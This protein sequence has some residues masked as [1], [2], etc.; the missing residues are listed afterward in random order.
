ML[1]ISCDSSG[2][3]SGSNNKSYLFFNISNAKAF[4]AGRDAQNTS[5][6]NILLKQD[7]SGDI[8]P[9]VTGTDNMQFIIHKIL[10]NPVTNELL[11][12]GSFSGYRLIRIDQNSNHYGL[13]AD[14]YH[15]Y[16]NADFDN[17][18]A[19]YFTSTGASNLAN[20]WKYENNTATSIAQSPTTSSTGFIVIHKILGNGYVAYSIQRSSG[21]DT[22]LRAQNGGLTSITPYISYDKMGVYSSYNNTWYYGNKGFDF[23][24]MTE[25][26]SGATSVAGGNDFEST[27]ATFTIIEKT[28]ITK[29]SIQS[30]KTL[31]ETV[32]LSGYSIEYK[33]IQGFQDELFIKQVNNI[34]YFAGKDTSNKR[35]F[36]KIVNEG[37]PIQ[38]L[39]GID[40][41]NFIFT[42]VSFNE[43]GHFIAYVQ[44][45]STGKY[46][47]L[48]GS[49]SDMQYT[50]TEKTEY[51]Q[52]TDILL[53]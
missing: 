43:D 50:F 21:W 26:N 27:G 34:V 51:V 24:T 44:Q 29:Y 45:L 16:Q 17:N 40:E 47:I 36:F 1:F 41:D 35:N 9:A 4:M 10:K 5:S 23:D 38:F 14:S 49:F 28:K 25:F 20:L 3:G 12:A 18:G 48:E 30:D 7:N 52:V 46:G 15:Y 6:N 53:Q 39:S 31:I 19:F 37:S 33:S 22:Y 8:V 2:S 11:L 13:S 32:V 42:N